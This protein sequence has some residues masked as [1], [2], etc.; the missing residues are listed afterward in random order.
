MSQT[1][2]KVLDHIMHR[3]MTTRDH[4]RENWKSWLNE[5]LEVN[6]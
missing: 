3:I 5:F 4:E 1:E 2:Q 6:A